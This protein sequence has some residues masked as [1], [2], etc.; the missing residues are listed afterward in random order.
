MCLLQR[1]WMCKVVWKRMP[2][3]KQQKDKT[4]HWWAEYERHER[5]QRW[6]LPSRLCKNFLLGVQHHCCWGA[7][8]LASHGRRVATSNGGQFGRWA[9]LE[10]VDP[11][12]SIHNLSISITDNGNYLSQLMGILLAKWNSNHALVLKFIW[13]QI[14]QQRW[15]WNLDGRS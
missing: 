3:S 7:T 15:G 6:S 14:N 8:T 5:H 12:R 9:Y 4:C 2:P 10:M 11:D 13:T 1:L